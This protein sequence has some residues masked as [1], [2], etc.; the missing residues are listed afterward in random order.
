MQINRTQVEQS[1]REYTNQYD[2]TD[3]KIKLK[4]DHTYRVADLCERL[5]KSISLS[6]EDVDL[7]WLCGMLHDVGRFEQLRRY[8]TFVDEQFIDHAVF[9]A[10]LLF[11]EEM[12]QVDGYQIPN[13]RSFVTDDAEDELLQMAVWCHSAY[14]MPENLDE[15]CEMFCDI[16]RDA[17]KI[18]IMRVNVDVPL[19][20]IYNVTTEELQ[21]SGITAEVLQAY[22][23]EHAV[24]RSLKKTPV[25]NIVGHMALVFEL[26]FPESI[27]IVRQ[28]GY[29]KQLMNYRSKNAATRKQF[30]Q[31]RAH[32][33][34]YM[35]ADD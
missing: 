28:Q 32:M 27:A 11:T 16:L 10:E 31:L 9:G 24:L 23:E 15:R 34:Q 33:E 14:R 29:L 18:D 22:E 3:S 35:K 12:R 20:E 6:K 30:E 8:G 17:D 19:E 13:I 21:Q 25:D 5:A 26:V 1:F 2:V 4:I 7:A